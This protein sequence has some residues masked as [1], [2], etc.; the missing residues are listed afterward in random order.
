MNENIY[1]NIKVFVINNATALE[2]IEKEYRNY[3]VNDCIPYTNM[4]PFKEIAEKV[5]PDKNGLW[6]TPLQYVV[7]YHKTI[8]GINGLTQTVFNFIEESNKETPVE[9]LSMC[10]AIEDDKIILKCLIRPYSTEFSF[11][12]IFDITGEKKELEEGV[13]EESNSG[14]LIIPDEYVNFKYSDEEEENHRRKYEAQQKIYDNCSKEMPF[15]NSIDRYVPK[16]LPDPKDKLELVYDLKTSDMKMEIL[17]P[18]EEF[19]EV[20]REIMNHVNGI[21]Y[22]KY[23]TVV[24]GDSPEEQFMGYLETY[25]RR[26]YIDKGRLREEDFHIMMKKLHKS[27][28]QLYIIQD[29]IDDPQ[30]T[31]I[32][33]TGPHEIR[34][35]VDGKAYISNISFID[36]N[37]YRRFVNM[38]CIRNNIY[39][40]VP[41]QTFTDDKDENYILRFS[42]TAQYVNSVKWP[43]LHIRKIA[44]QKLM[45]DDLIN[46]GMFTEKIRD[47]ILDCGKNSRGIV[48]AGP[49]GCGKT[50]FLNW[51]LEEAYEQEA[52]ILVIQENDELFASR[53]GVMFQHVVNYPN[54]NEYPV[55]L[56]ELGQ[57]ALV[58]G[59]NVFIIGEVKGAEICSAI[60]LSNSGCRTAMTL[61][62]PS[63]TETID[64]MA[65]LAMRGYAKDVEQA[66]RMLRS[67]QTIVYLENFH[68]K[69]ISEIVGFD[70]EKKDMIYKYIYRE[71]A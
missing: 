42:L 32:K 50:I 44:R 57:L 12:K 49:P 3:N 27:L 7:S 69:E 18:Y 37:D 60:T 66:K 16:N 30:V 70:E 10:A 52:E 34:A 43:Y 64:K 68:V 24:K 33:I 6:K 11:L 28:F 63:S 61:H 23:I 1:K 55:S 47:Y 17:T 54:E 53:K 25:I 59:A 5:I 22:Y 39:Q 2:K 51:F 46:A 41:E 40:S 19:T 26:N 48:I 9:L 67:F 31:D 58:A 8:L 15:L 14:N 29:L 38:I 4:T 35:R 21:E 36:E 56:E 65:D 62:T 13:K 20:F 45:A 71:D